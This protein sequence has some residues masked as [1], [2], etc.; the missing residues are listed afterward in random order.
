MCFNIYVDKLNLL[1]LVL[2]GFFLNTCLA[3]KKN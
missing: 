3:N 1:L 2:Y